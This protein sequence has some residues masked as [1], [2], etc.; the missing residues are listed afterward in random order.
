VVIALVDDAEI[1][2][3]N[4]EFLEHDWPTDVI[5]FSYAEDEKTLVPAGFRGAG[6]V[7]DGE[8]VVS[9]E[10]A[11][12]CAAV[13]GWSFHAELLLYCV[14]GLLHLCGY[15]DLTDAERPIMRR[16]ERELLAAFGLSPVNLES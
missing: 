11:V 4:R 6:R 10:T 16:R 13:H 1:H 5:S 14:H 8:L 7:L 15:D 12:R 2:R 3:V 9:V